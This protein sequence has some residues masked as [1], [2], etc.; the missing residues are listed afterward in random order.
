MKP[1]LL[2]LISFLTIKGALCFSDH[3]GEDTL[4]FTVRLNDKPD[5]LYY[6]SRDIALVDLLSGPVL[7][8]NNN[9]LFYSRFGYALYDQKGTLLHSHSLHQQ[10]RRLKPGNPNRLSL[11]YPTDRSTILYYKN[12]T[13]NEIYGNKITKKRMRKIGGDEAKQ[14]GDPSATQI[15]N[16]AYNTL[17]SEMV[18]RTYSKPGLVGF[19]LQTE[20]RWWSLEKRYSFTS[21][22]IMEQ[23]ER[24]GSFFPGVKVREGLRIKKFLI[25]PLSVVQRE[26]E[27]YYYGLKASTGSERS[28]Y[29]QQVLLCDE[30]GNILRLDTLLKQTIRETVLEKRGTR[31][32]TFERTAQWGFPPWVDSL[33]T[34]FY[35]ILDYQNREIV[36]RKRSYFYYA[37]QPSGPMLEQKL[38][39][40]QRVS[41]EAM[42][43]DHNSSVRSGAAVP[44]VWIMNEDGEKQKAKIRDLTTKKHIVRLHRPVYRNITKKIS[45][46]RSH[47]PPPVAAMQDS[48]SEESTCWAPY[49]ISLSNRRGVMCS[50]DYGAADRLLCARVLNVVDNRQVFV[51]VDLEG[52]AEVVVFDENGGFVNRLTFNKQ[53]HLKRKDAVAVSDKGKIAEKD[54][55]CTEGGYRFYQW[56]PT[57]P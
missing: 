31:E 34:L 14:Y 53:H 42:I 13:P 29:Y 23:K 47:L 30:A 43:L 3:H 7:V 4:L 48:L 35:G 21:P 8:E 6:C 38:R 19:D 16:I 15:L 51:R 18:E 36:V 10:N 41:Y 26:G 45:K 24:F 33:G 12:K 52:R 22:T 44:V 11:A 27:R 1:Y 2:F 28:E 40:E 56:T 54:Y 17:T 5:N 9:L 55:E 20:T 46:S 37:P 57:I 49:S 39:D 25:E 32:Y 50:F